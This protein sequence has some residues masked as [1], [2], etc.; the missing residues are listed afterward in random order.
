LVAR[1]KE[2]LM[3]QRFKPI[4]LDQMNEQQR[5]VAQTLIDGP[6][7]GLRGPFN[8]L[9]RNPTLTDRVRLLGD[10]IRFESTLEPLHREFAILITAKFWSADYEWCVHSK[11]ALEYGLGFAVV[12]AIRVGEEPLL[13]DADL[14]LIYRFTHEILFDKDVSDAT[15]AKAIERFGELST[16]DLLSTIGYFGFVS[17]I[18]NAIRQPIPEGAIPLPRKGVQP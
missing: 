17:V 1:L 18:L 9:L 3:T 15:Y 13:S 2:L 4:A 12:D 5:A 16:L 10:S 14:S 6:R 8:A 7:K 11:L